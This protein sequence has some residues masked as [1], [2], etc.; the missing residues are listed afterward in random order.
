MLEEVNQY[1][2]L[3]TQYL[4]VDDLQGIEIILAATVSHKLQWGEMLWLRVIGASGTGKTEILRSLLAQEPFAVGMERITPGSIRRGW[5]DKKSKTQETLLERLDGKLAITKE[6]GVMLTEDSTVQNAVF[7]LLRSVYDGSLDA[8]Y[9]SEQGHY[10]QEC[11]FDWIL[12]STA[13]IEKSRAL[14]YWLGSR[15]VD[16]RWGS[17]GDRLTAVG[18]AREN[19]QENKLNIFRGKLARAMANIL[20]VVPMD[21][22]QP[23][24]SYI[25]ELGDIAAQMRSPV[26]RDRR[27]RE[28]EDLPEK[29]LGTR[30]GQ[31]LSRIAAGLLMIGVEEK[32]IKPYIN[33]LVLNSMSRIRA[34][35]IQAW[36][37]G[38]SSQKVIAARLTISQGAVSRVIGDM[39]LLGWRSE[40]VDLLT[41]SDA[42]DYRL[43]RAKARL[44]EIIKQRPD[45]LLARDIGEERGEAPG[46]MPLIDKKVLDGFFKSFDGMNNGE[47]QAIIQWVIEMAQTGV[48]QRNKALAKE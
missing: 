46:G 3:L 36:I 20:D 1:E 37:D 26:E 24:F 38:V 39:E 32:D 10:H 5:V 42:I 9:G 31:A 47:K 4:E 19:I 30:M 43:E 25:D 28:I 14:E 17:P 45:L 12:G 11:F 15:F 35:V 40:W 33:R 27:N 22:S 6:Y 8:D 18:K 29:E 48:K 21:I 34:A 13:I 23:S 41:S 2:S 16:L 7:G 44:P